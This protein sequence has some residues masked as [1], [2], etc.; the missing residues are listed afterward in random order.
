MSRSV[1]EHRAALKLGIQPVLNTVKITT[2][3]FHEGDP[4]SHPSR[5]MYLADM[6]LVLS[7]PA[8]GRHTVM[9]PGSPVYKS[10]VE[11]KGM[12]CGGCQFQCKTKLMSKDEAPDEQK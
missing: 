8:C 4:L 2:E 3:A 10:V 1:E 12:R 7:C 6:T 11:G 5:Y 9:T